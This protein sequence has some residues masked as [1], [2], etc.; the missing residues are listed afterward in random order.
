ME[1][2]IVPT[3]LRIILLF[4]SCVS[5]WYIVRKLRQSQMQLLDALYWLLV[6]FMLCIFGFFPSIPVKL[7][8]VVGVISPVNLVYLIMLFIALLRCFLLSIR[9]SKIENNFKRLVEELAVRTT[10]EKNEE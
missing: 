7:A 6:A 2:E 4:S 9:I 8:E 1:G 5:V 10:I 3:I